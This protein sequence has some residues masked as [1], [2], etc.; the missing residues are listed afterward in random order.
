MKEDKLSSLEGKLSTAIEKAIE[1]ER[2]SSDKLSDKISLEFINKFGEKMTLKTHEKWGGVYF[3]HTDIHEDDTYYPK[4][5]IDFG[6]LLDSD[7]K[8]VINLFST[9]LYIQKMSEIK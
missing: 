8:Q 6:V 4:A 5:V 2:V 3:N 9:L 1:S 7:E